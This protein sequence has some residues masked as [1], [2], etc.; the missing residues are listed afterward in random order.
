MSMDER[1]QAAEAATDE[2]LADA[3]REQGAWQAP[4]TWPEERSL[5]GILI[6][7]QMTLEEIL[8]ELK[9]G[10]SIERTG[11]VS[12]IEIQDNPTKDLKVR[13]NSKTYAGSALPVYEALRDHARLHREA[14]QAAMDGW[15]QTIE[16]LAS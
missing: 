4:S 12:S 13:V 6:S 2:A 5:A 7:M 15:A 9:R 14:E 8:G 3:F 16:R 10:N 1:K 11:S